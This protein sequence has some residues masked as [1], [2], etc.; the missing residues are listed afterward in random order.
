ML[1]YDFEIIYKRGKKNVVAD[2]LSRRPIVGRTEIPIANI[3]EM[4][5]TSVD[6]VNTSILNQNEL[7]CTNSELYTVTKAIYDARNA[8]SILR[9]NYNS[10][11]KRNCV[12]IGVDNVICAVPGVIS[13]NL[14]EKEISEAKRKV[15]ILAKRRSPFQ[16]KPH[17]TQW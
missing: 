4:I 16:I 12:E 13:D 6:G 7:S 8:K 11:L 3:T 15:S 9:R 2:A 14:N 17:I 1:S 10:N 5:N